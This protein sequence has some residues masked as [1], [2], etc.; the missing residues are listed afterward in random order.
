MQAGADLR[1]PRHTQENKEQFGSEIWSY[2]RGTKRK[3]GEVEQL[4]S[5]LTSEEKQIIVV[6]KENSGSWGISQLDLDDLSLRTLVDTNYAERAVNSDADKLYYSSNYS[7]QQ[8]IYEYNLAS[9]T[10]SQLTN[11]GYAFDGV[12]CSD[13]LY[14]T[15]PGAEGIGLYSKAQEGSKYNLPPAEE[16]EE[17]VINL[18]QLGSEV[19]ESSAVGSNFGALVPPNMRFLPFLMRGQDALGLNNYLINYDGSV[20]WQTKLFKPLEV[21][22]SNSPADGERNTN[23]DLSYPLYNSALQGLTSLDFNYTT[24]FSQSISG[25]QLGFTYPTQDISFNL[26]QYLNQQGTNGRVTYKYKLDNSGIKINGSRYVDFER[27]DNL[28][29]SKIEFA[30]GDDGYQVSEEYTHKL[31]ELRKGW[32]KQK[33]FIGDIYG[34]QFIEYAYNS[35]SEVDKAAYGYQLLGELYW[36]KSLPLTIK[37]STAYSDGDFKSNWGVKVSF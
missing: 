14:F 25:L 10:V 26:Q 36:W 37:L 8:S 29:V 30:T 31:L 32:W 9:E 35:A 33:L 13:K 6:G 16:I 22:V 23:L 11:R 24:D 7:G 18:D 28:R 1:G 5:E 2:Q 19:E 3:I 34:N 20:A 15:A 17:E 12:V 4:I 21:T 27:E